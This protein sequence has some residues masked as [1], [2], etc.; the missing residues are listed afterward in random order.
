MSNNPMAPSWFA[1]RIDHM[2]CYNYGRRKMCFCKIEYVNC[3]VQ[4]KMTLIAALFDH[5]CPLI[6]VASCSCQDDVL[7]L[8]E[9]VGSTAF[10][11]GSFWTES[12]CLKVPV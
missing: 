3:E 4:G 7:S 1:V 10:W 2:M 8:F 6:G 11:T 9:S 12:K 5:G